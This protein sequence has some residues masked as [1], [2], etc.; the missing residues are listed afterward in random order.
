MKAVMDALSPRHPAQRVVFMKAAQVGATEADNNWIGFCMHRAPGP[1]LAVQPTVDLAK[2]LSQQR[3]DPLV[4][5]S[6]DL[7]AL[8]LPSRSPDAGNT[9]LGKRF[10]G[11]P[12]DP[13]RGQQRRWLVIDARA[14]GVSRRG[15]HLCRL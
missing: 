7:R 13:D 3:I 8:V 4:E 5:E 9:I 2:R 14:L 1:F 6:P 10:P 15:R 12:V 11:R